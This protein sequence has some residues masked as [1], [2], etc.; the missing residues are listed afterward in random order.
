[1]ESKKAVLAAFA[2]N[3][4]IA[5]AKFGGFLVTGSSSLLSESVHSL[6]DSAN[7][8]LLLVG[9]KHADT[10]P[11][12][13]HPFGKNGARYVYGFL[14]AIIIFT[15]GGMFSVYEG[16]HKIQHP[17]PLQ[18][19]WIAYLVLLFAILAEGFALR[20]AL[21]AT[22]KARKGRGFFHFIRRSRNP[23]YPVLLIEDS[24]ALLGLTI[25]IIAITLTVLTGNGVYDGIGSVLIG[26][27]LIS[28]AIMLAAE[29]GSLLIGES[30]VP[31]ECDQIAT[32]LVDGQTITSLIHLRTLHVGPDVLLVTAKVGVPTGT[33][34]EQ[35][36]VAV[37]AA[38]A[39]IRTILP[40]AKYIFVEPDLARVGDIPKHP[41]MFPHDPGDE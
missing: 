36:V 13:A 32:L 33:T 29:T 9:N 12:R 4:S 37:N 39:R 38:E 30:A 21:N 26:I 41:Q 23:E 25:A 6:A 17:E 24:G 22:R 34:I 10:K 18:H 35:I 15:V 16:V 2:A 8:I 27:L 19:V 5:G 7:Q 31:E 14:V 11:T 20:T 3:L 1:M 28:A 40:K